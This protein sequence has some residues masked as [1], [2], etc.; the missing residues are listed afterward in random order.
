[1]SNADKVVAKTISASGMGNTRLDRPRGKDGKK[2]I[3]VIAAYYLEVIRLGVR[4]WALT[5]TS[6][7]H[8][9]DGEGGLAPGSWCFIRNRSTSP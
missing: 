8:R 3:L 4:F 1:M 5:R 6:E 2:R 7:I 9:W